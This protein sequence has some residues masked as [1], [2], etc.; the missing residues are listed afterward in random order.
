MKITVNN[1]DISDRLLEYTLNMEMN[2]DSLLLGNTICTQVTMKLDNQ[3]GNMNALLDQPFLI[4]NDNISLTG[5]FYVYE[6]PEKYTGELELT[7]YDAV[8]RFEQRYDTQLTYPVTINDQLNEMASMTGLTIDKTN[9]RT[10]TLQKSVD[11]YDNTVSMR[12]Y[13]GWI[14]E[15]DG[16][17]VFASSNG[18]IIFRPLAS[19]QYDSVDLESYSKGDLVH[20]SR[21]CF[22]NGILKL[23]EGSDT[24]NTLYLSSNNGYI[25]SDTSLAHIYD[26]YQ[27]LSF[28]AIEDVRMM[29]ING[30]FLTDLI[31]YND[32]FLFM[33]LSVSE[34]YTGGSYAIATVSGVVNTA[35]NEAVINKIDDAVRIKRLQT[36]IDQNEQTLSILNE[37]LTDGLGKISAFELALDGITESVSQTEE[38]VDEVSQ[39]PDIRISSNYGVQQVFSPSTG[40]YIPDWST[41]ALVLTPEIRVLGLIQP[42]DPTKITWTKKNGELGANEQVTNGLLKINANILEENKTL[43]YEVVYTYGEEK[44]A[45]AEVSLSMVSDGTEGPK[46]DPGENVKSVKL[47]AD[48]S[49]F[50]DTI[51][52]DVSSDDNSVVYEHSLTPET[53]HLTAITSDCMFDV[54]QYSTDG[55][56]WNSVINGQHGF[57]VSDHVLSIANTSDLLASGMLVI[58]ALTSAENVIDTLTVTKQ[59]NATNLISEIGEIRSVTEVKSTDI[60]KRVDEIE[61]KVKNEVVVKTDIDDIESKIITSIE[62]STRQTAEDIR[63][64]FTSQI[65]TVQ[66][67]ISTIQ[68]V[69][70]YIRKSADGIE[71]GAS[72]TDTSTLT[73]SDGFHIK[74]KGQDAAIFK[75]DQLEVANAVHEKSVKVGKVITQA[76]ADGEIIDI[77]VGD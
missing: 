16:C 20:F 7:L 57:T 42:L 70:N 58:K 73:A 45:T 49:V 75:M 62:S 10:A 54:F 66:K 41:Q 24:G 22:D 46:G 37:D 12:N 50:T 19:G 44:T 63:T 29:N 2:E 30:W 76:T 72:N 77:W 56:V 64:E 8:Y 4:Y 47:T 25:D 28:Y 14:A 59:T 35:N 31:N 39:K 23:E 33:P 69:T 40:A 27:N 13:L 68:S 53:V 18:H 1:L 65:E 48:C 26:M 15:L 17:N 38:K 74:Y 6:K 61:S 67:D 5:T 51:S 21:V 60:S 34:S 43:T 71:V 11:W 52:K 36:M 3:D 32:A 9:L 55:V